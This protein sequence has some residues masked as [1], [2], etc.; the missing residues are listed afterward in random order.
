MQSPLPAFTHSLKALSAILAKAEAHCADRNIEPSVLLTARLFPDM[1]NFIRNVLAAC[2]TAK[3][4]A[5]RLSE[6]DNPRFEDNETSFAELQ[7]RIQK[8]LDFMATVPDSA[9]EGA[10]DRIVNMKAGARDLTFTGANYLSVFATPNFYFHMATAYNILRHNG[11]E[12]GK[13]DFLGGR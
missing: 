3:G 7:A 12:I 10:E 8:T 6:T 2:D 9:F 4:A 13:V 1:M 5:A 11:V